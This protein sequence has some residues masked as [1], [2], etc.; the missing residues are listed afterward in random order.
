L[1][2]ALQAAHRAARGRL[3]AR[4]DADDIAHPERLAE[5]VAYLDEHRDVAV[6][7][8]RVRVTDVDGVAPPRGGFSRY[9]S[10]LNRLQTPE[11]HAAERFIESPLAHPSVVMRREAFESVGGYRDPGWPE[12]YDLWLR[13]FD[14]GMRVAK[15]P[16]A[17]LTWRDRPD[18]LSR[19]DPRY[20][21]RQFQRAKAHY[22]ARVA[23]VRRRGVAISGG[24]ANGKAMARLLAAEGVRVHALYDVSPRRIGRALE[25][26]T[27]ILDA[28]AM[29]EAARGAPI[30][31]AAVAQP[32]G[33]EAIREIATA[34][35]YREGKDF[36]CVA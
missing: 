7:G 35:G 25:D 2:A 36:F 9:Q 21:R 3:L 30:Q 12:D 32:G 16:R 33:R 26:G 31:L 11:E 27:P 29:P 34:H 1:I 18:R 6:V 20:A 8:C 22:L 14:A 5:Q 23:S 10:W 28:E 4:M 15:V 19:I 13:M 24:G 17:L